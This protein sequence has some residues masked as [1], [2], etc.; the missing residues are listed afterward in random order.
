MLIRVSCNYK[1]RLLTHV[2]GEYDFKVLKETVIL[3]HFVQITGC[4]DINEHSLAAV[5]MRS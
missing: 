5:K 1:P 4:H 3:V 2:S